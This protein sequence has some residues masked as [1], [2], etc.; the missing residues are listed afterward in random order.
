MTGLSQREQE[1]LDLLCQEGYT[2]LELAAVLNVSIETVKRHLV[3]IMNKTGYSSRLELVVKTLHA[4]RRMAL[5][6]ACIADT[7]GRSFTIPPCDLFIHAGDWT[8]GGSL[9]ETAALA[10]WLAEQPQAKRK[11]LVPGNHDLVAQEEP[12][13]IKAMFGGIADILIDEALE[14]D[15]RHFWFSPWTPPFMNWAWMMTEPGLAEVVYS[16]MP[17]E[18]DM[19]ITHGPPRGILDPGHKE[20]HV[21]STA[22]LAAIQSRQIR[23]H[24][25]G[26]LHAAGGE[27]ALLFESEA[28][29]VQTTLHN[30]AAVDEAYKMRRG[31]R[32]IEL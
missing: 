16:K 20:P 23:H 11:A 10:G 18:L 25:F 3:T 24:V 29:L 19:L 17:Q 28:P 1:I 32:I 6:V 26:H 4:R 12:D 7:H 27:T 22:L 21:G 31:C 30:V 13:R 15:G 2:N 5:T 9:A 14:V 8:G